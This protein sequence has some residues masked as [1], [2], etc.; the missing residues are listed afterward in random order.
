MI[1]YWPAIGIG[2]DV[3]I[4]NW[5]DIVL[6]ARPFESSISGQ[7]LKSIHDMWTPKRKL[8]QFEKGK[9]EPD[10]GGNLFGFVST[11]KED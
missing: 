1:G 8:K 2:R 11:I 10:L 3:D 4:V 7:T 6:G 5:P 9:L